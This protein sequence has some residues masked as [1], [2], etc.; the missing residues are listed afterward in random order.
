MYDWRIEQLSRSNDRSAFSC[1]KSPLDDFIRRFVTQYEKRNLGRTFVAVLEGE[2][3]IGGY[4]T[5]ASSSVTFEHLP[6]ESPR[7]LPKHPVPVV[8]IARLAVDTS[9]QGQK[10]GEKLLI[11]ALSRCLDL[12]EQ[13]GVHAVEVDAIDYQ[14]RS[15][16]LKYGFVSLTDDP[17]HLF[18]PVAT[19]RDALGGSRLQ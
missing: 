7:T 14:A 8:L 15:F 5:L 9:V 18:L 2:N 12:A 17:R 4:Y 1:G 11:D 6:E 3:R 19:I 13:L 16:Y 10:L